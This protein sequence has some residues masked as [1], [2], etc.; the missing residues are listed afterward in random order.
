MCRCALD[1]AGSVSM[2]SGIGRGTVAHLPEHVHLGQGVLAR[3]LKPS[4]AAEFPGVDTR[5]AA[6]DDELSM[7]TPPRPTL[8][9][10]DF[11]ASGLPRRCSSSSSR[12]GLFS[13]AR[14]PGRGMSFPTHVAEPCARSSAMLRRGLSLGGKGTILGLPVGKHVVIF[15][16]NPQKVSLAHAHASWQDGGGA[17]EIPIFAHAQAIW[18]MAPWRGPSLQRCPGMS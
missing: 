8:R 1:T 11:I 4:L 9:Q 6:S 12:S 16:P 2:A 18:W 14:H 17:C 15:A 5:R 13:W 3:P 7:W 10:S